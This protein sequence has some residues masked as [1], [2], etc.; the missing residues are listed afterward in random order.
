MKLLYLWTVVLWMMLSHSTSAGIISTYN[1]QSDF[2]AATSATSLTGSYGTVPFAETHTFNDLTFSTSAYP[3]TGSLFTAD[4][5]TLMPG[6]ELGLNGTESI[7]IQYNP[8][9]L[10]FAFGFYFVEPTATNQLI[11][12]TNTPFFV[13]SLFTISLYNDNTLIDSFVFDPANDQVVFMGFETDMGFNRLSI[14]EPLTGVTYNPG[15]A[16][17]DTSNEN[18]YFGEMFGA[19][20]VVG[21]PVP[22]PASWSMLLLIF[23]ALFIGRNTRSVEAETVTNA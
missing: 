20:Q 15:S 22:E 4:Y 2:I 1:N 17:V 13:E 8:S 10:L 19:T 18:E 11:D 21:V 14:V 23:L 3:E 6:N 9:Q 7:D 5:S 12:G 16:T